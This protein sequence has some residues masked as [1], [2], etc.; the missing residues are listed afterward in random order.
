MSQPNLLA[1]PLFRY[2]VG[3]SGAAMVAAVAYLYLEGTT[4]LV[5]YAIA[6]L[7]IVVTPQILKWAAA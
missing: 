3:A 4:Q 5:A 6:V 1:N 2:G 7:D